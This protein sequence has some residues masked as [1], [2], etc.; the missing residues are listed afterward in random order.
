MELVE[1]PLQPPI[2]NASIAMLKK[3]YFWKS[4]QNFREYIFCTNISLVALI[5]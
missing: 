1:D 2:K 3:L 4:L 5:L